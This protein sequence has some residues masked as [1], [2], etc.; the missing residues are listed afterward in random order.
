[1]ALALRSLHSY[2][3][4]DAAVANSIGDAKEFDS[5]AP[6]SLHGPVPEHRLMLVFANGPYFGGAF[7]IAPGAS[8]TDGA[9][10]MIAIR[11]ASTF[12][13]LTLLARATRGAHM[14]LEETEHATVSEALV[15][16]DEPPQFEADGEPHRAGSA[17]VRVAC[18]PGALNVIPA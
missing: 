11:D 16:F 6:Q 8:V 2:R 17:R 9:L 7:C 3:G 13:R 10:D 12:R 4:F 15:Q 14:H 5:T 1:A 18:I